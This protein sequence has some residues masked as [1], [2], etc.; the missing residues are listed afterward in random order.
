VNG[1]ELI[2]RVNHRLWKMRCSCGNEF[3]SQ[4]SS[5][6]GRC[7]ECGYKALSAMR[8]IHGESPKS[9][10]RNA[11]RLYR[12]WAGMRNRCNNPQNKCFADYGG[13][14]ITVCDSWSDYEVFKAW[15]MG[16]GYTEELTIDRIDNDGNYCPETCRLATMLEQSQN[17]RK[18]G[19]EAHD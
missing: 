16:N 15:A 4:P 6:S 10:K 13:R 2:E 18:K 19:V 3:V 14:G 12:I 9:G 7:R 8:E 1:A 11:T 17:K 5:T